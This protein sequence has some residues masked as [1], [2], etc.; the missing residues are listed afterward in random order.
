MRRIFTALIKWYV[1]ENV[2]FH[3]NGCCFSGD[4]TLKP[5]YKRPNRN[6][7]QVESD[8]GRGSSMLV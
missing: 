2:A 7:S 4:A 8:G 1:P 5:N 6:S 3:K